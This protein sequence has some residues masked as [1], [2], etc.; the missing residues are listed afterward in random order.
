MKSIVINIKKL[1]PYLLLIALYFF[2]VNIEAGKE[3][4]NN[5]K[6]IENIEEVNEK[7]FNTRIRIPVI[8]YQK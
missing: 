2:F 4:N 6:I 7:N 5:H 8:P 3:K 1:I